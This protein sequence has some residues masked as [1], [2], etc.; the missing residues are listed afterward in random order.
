MS[1]TRTSAALDRRS[2]TALL[3]GVAGSAAA[4]TP[5]MAATLRRVDGSRLQPERSQ[6]YIP[7]RGLKA[8]SDLF[9]RMTVPVH[10]NGQGPFPFVLD[11][12]AN[13]SVICSELAA[14]LGLQMG[15]QAPINGVAGMEMADTVRLDSFKA[16]DL[17]QAGVTLSVLPQAPLGGRGFIGL[18]L[19]ERQRL[20]LDFKRQRITIE[21]SRKAV[22]NPYDFVLNATYKAGQL[23]LVNG[24]IG[25]IPVTA[26]L[27][28]GAQTTI[29]N[30]A[31]RQLA[32][33]RMPD[34]KWTATEVLSA[35]G[36]TIRGDW[37]VLHA[38]RL[39]AM[40]LNY[41]PVVFADLHTFRIWDLVKAPAVLV[42]VDI[43]SQFEYVSLDFARGEVR[44]RPPRQL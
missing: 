38:F 26:F 3:L 37:A 34:L 4:A 21:S 11:T 30:Q 44:F 9:A 32:S 6:F 2:L 13:Q 39:G 10:I 22:R 8:S 36:Q 42:G 41:L 31:L 29:G 18:D 33:S 40:T 12:G 35:T 20:T 1:A 15:P 16:G 7:P 14:Q 25:G 19:I 17:E 24:D 23:T 43:M 5:A 28:S 27:D